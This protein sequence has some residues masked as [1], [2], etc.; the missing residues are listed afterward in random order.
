MATIR[1]FWHHLIKPVPAKMIKTV[2]KSAILGRACWENVEGKRGEI[3]R[4]FV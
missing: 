2:K 1:S 4:L 3:S